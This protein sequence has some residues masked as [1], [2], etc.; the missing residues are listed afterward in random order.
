MLKRK[1]FEFDYKFYYLISKYQAWL[2]G[3]KFAPPYACTF[4]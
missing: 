4:M 2:F 1:L 3:T